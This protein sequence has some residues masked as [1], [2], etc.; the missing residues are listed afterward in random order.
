MPEITP[1]NHYFQFVETVLGKNKTTTS[2][3][4][5][6]PLTEAVLLGPLATHF[7]KTTLE[8]NAAKMKFTNSPEATRLVRRQ[9]RAGWHVKGLS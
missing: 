2:F 9:Y 4:Y 5:S 1:V 7:P 3:D 8:W 6:G